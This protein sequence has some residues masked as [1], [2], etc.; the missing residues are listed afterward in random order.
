MVQP[1]TFKQPER[2]SLVGGLAKLA[3][4]AEDVSRGSYTLPLPVSVLSERAALL[5]DVLPSYAPE[6][7]VSEWGIGWTARLSIQ[8][9]RVT[10]DIDYQTDEFISPWGRLAMG[11]DGFYY[12]AGLKQGVKLDKQSDRWVAISPSGTSTTFLQ[13]VDTPEGPYAWYPTKVETLL[14]DVTEIE[15]LTSAGGRPFV[16]KVHYGSVDSPQTYRLDFEYETLSLA[17]VD[18]RAGYPLLLDRRVKRLVAYAKEGGQGTP[19]ERWSY[20]FSYRD[21]EFGPGF[22]LDSVKRTYS[23]GEIE[24]PVTYEYDL[25]EEASATGMN[26]RTGDLQEA[27]GVQGYLDATGSQDGLEPE[28]AAPT[29]MDEDGLADLEHSID[30]TMFRQTTAGTFIGQPLPPPPAGVDTACRPPAGIFNRARTLVRMAG[31]GSALQVLVLEEGSSTTAI[32]VCSLAGVRQVAVEVPGLWHLDANM[33]VADL[34][35]DH[36]PDL[37]L[38]DG[39]SYKVLENISGQGCPGPNCVTLGFTDHAARPLAFS[40][41]FPFTPTGTWV[42]DING[43][44]NPDLI[45]RSSDRMSVWYGQGRFLFAGQE[46]RLPLIDRRDSEMFNLGTWE[47]AWV[48]ANK[49]GLTDALMKKHGESMLFINEVDRFQEAVAPALEHANHFGLGGVLVGDYRGRGDLDLNFLPVTGAAA[50]NLTLP[51]TGLLLSADDGKGTRASF[52]Y[53]RAPAVAGLQHRPAI[54]SALTVSTAGYDPITYEYIY[55]EPRMHTVGHFLVGFR[56]VQ[57]DAPKTRN[58]VDFYHDDVVTGQVDASRSF[59]D[60]TPGLMKFTRTSH[61]EALHA[62]VRVRRAQS[63]WTGWCN[64]TDVATCAKAGPTTASVEKTEVLAYERGICPTRVRNTN[65]HGQVITETRLAAPALLG[66]AL[67]CVSDGQVWSGTHADASHNF[68]LEGSLTLNDLGQVTKVEQIGS[69]VTLTLQEIA[70]DPLTHRVSSIS[71]PG[72][73]IQTFTYDPE[74]GHLEST[75]AA[76]GVITRAQ[77]RDVNTD[78]LL[79]LV[80][81][82]G[83]G[84]ALTSSFRYDGFER[85]ATRWADFGGSSETQPLE[86]IE[87]QF[88]TADFPALIQ[89]SSLVDAAAQIRQESASW[90]YPDGA[91]LTSATHV[92]GR[93]VFDGL[94]TASRADLRTQRHRRAPLPDSSDLALA[95]YPSLLEQTTF[96]GESLAAGFG[97]EVGGRSVVQQGVEQSVATS[98]A[99]TNGLIVTIAREN[100]TFETKRSADASGRTVSFRDQRSLTTQYQR[101]A[102]GRLVGVTLPNG[103]R[104]RLSFDVFGRPAQIVRDGIGTVTYA[105]EP[106]TG[107]LE[108]KDYLDRAGTLERTCTYEYDAIGRVTRQ[109]HVKSATEV[110]TAFT[111]RYDGDVGDG[112]VVPGQKGYTTKVEGPAYT[113][114]T[115]RN[116]DGTEATSSIILAGWMQIDIATTYYASGTPSEVHRTITRLSDG[117]VIDDVATEY[118]YDAWGRLDRTTVNGEVL[119]ALHY[120]EEGRIASVDLPEGQRIE[121]TYDPVTHRQAG[122]GQEITHGDESWQTGV[123]WTFNNRGLVESEGLDLGDQSW[124]RVYRYDPRGFLTRSQDVDQLSTYTYTN[125]GLPNQVTDEHGTR[126]VFRGSA[127]TLTVGDI[128]YTWDQSGRLIGRGD[129]AFSYGPDGHLSEADIGPRTLQYASDA[130]GNR[131]LKFEGGDPVAA[132]VGGGVLTNE[133]FIS[134]VKIGGRL[135][136][137]LERGEFQALATDPRGTVLADRDGTQHLATPYGVRATRPDLSAALDY[138]EKAYD[139]DLGSVRMGV[140]DYD[141]LLGQ[142]WT[143]DP[144]FLEALDKCAENPVS[145]NLFSYARNNPITFVDPTGMDEEGVRSRSLALLRR[146]AR[147]GTWIMSIT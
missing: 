63:T 65:R 76:D 138:I 24:P 5:S 35:R 32:K 46:I 10:G 22:F 97:H 81:D 127:D 128:Q 14:G 145:C 112:E 86:A 136:G 119:A 98:L 133:G 54:L 92:P 21:A 101:D 111:F 94:S 78:A 20:A 41:G 19:R 28:W 117:A 64:G 9:F 105:Y 79:E 91:E 113:A 49:D 104:H 93:W 62:G 143:P 67:H 31:V 142:F 139:A 107:R 70:Y 51:S 146:G 60:R 44:G 85:L 147:D 87:Y 30:F 58:V 29:D 77:N 102:L 42:H 61:E 109:T 121:H 74:T 80:G 88:P 53:E 118:V 7:G 68:R 110:E 103:I 37:I 120:D 57:V 56:T 34:N 90:F 59:D 1:P 3:I 36:K 96:L 11:N 18:Y 134:P 137:I 55:G 129:A 4:G 99:L 72:Q 12:P 69:D 71:A 8:R 45:L 89:V 135:V 50:A 43:D 95:T 23:S 16:S 33:K 38:V 124:L 48:D 84:G 132:Y 17:L 126:T 73:G 15:Y 144:L 39:D 115:L 123:D 82:R 114:T 47:V 130:E 125:A 122:Y 106:V 52:A 108:H 75:T 13:K 141:P 6:N 131:L 25:P 40:G 140:R 83:V 66:A 2:G 100:D 27:P 116:P 26:Y